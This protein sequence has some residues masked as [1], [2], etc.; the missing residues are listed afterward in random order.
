M[1]EF[2]KMMMNKMTEQSEAHERAMERMADA[3]SNID[4]GG[5]FP[6]SAEAMLKSGP[7]VTMDKLRVGDYVLVGN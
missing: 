5:C 2:Q 4:T 6:A 7:S 1:V 3:I